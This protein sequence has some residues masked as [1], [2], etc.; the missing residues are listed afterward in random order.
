MD[1]VH[2]QPFAGRKIRIL[3]VV[4]TFTRLAPAI[5]ALYSYRGADVVAMLDK[6]TRE[7]GYPKAIRLDNGPE[8]VSREL[9]LWAFMHDV[10]FDFSRLGQADR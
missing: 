6:A 9:D 4:D 7:L 3:T 10:T 8:L 2:D 1:F 5:D